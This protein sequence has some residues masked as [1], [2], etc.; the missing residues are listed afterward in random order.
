V[1][2]QHLATKEIIW[3]A[4]ALQTHTVSNSN[5]IEFSY[6]SQLADR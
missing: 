2:F 4:L 6:C 3:L 1:T 5:L